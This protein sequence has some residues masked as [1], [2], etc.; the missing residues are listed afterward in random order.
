MDKLPGPPD[1]AVLAGLPPS[2]AN[3]GPATPLWRVHATEGEHPSA[4]NEMRTWGPAPGCRFDPHEPPPRV[5]DEKVLY[6]AYDVPTA[7]AE[8]YQQ[9]RRIVRD[10]GAP[11]L[12]GFTV[13]RTL[14]LLNLTGN[15]PLRIGA[16]HSINADV[17]K[18][19]TRAWAR[20]LRLAFSDADGL[21]SVSSMT[22]R[23]TVTLFAPAEDALP[24]QP[25][26][27]EPLGSAALASRLRAAAYTIGYT[28]V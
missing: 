17:D 5:Q 20:A 14:R 1:P 13:S 28:V 10:A 3:L 18:A 22:G 4:W 2:Y 21:L 9:H 7:L 19:K 8:V 15:W 23:R 27:S 25:A 24:D 6:A 12:T 16:A 26:F 11:Y